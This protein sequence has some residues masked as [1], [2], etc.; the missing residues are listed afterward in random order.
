VGIA[1]V[2]LI[3]GMVAPAGAAAKGQLKVA[4]SLPAP[5]FWNGDTPAALNGGYE[6]GIAKDIAKRLGYSGFSVKNVSFDALVAGKVKG[7]DVALSQV[8]ITPERAKVVGFTVPYFNSDLGILVKKGTTVDKSNL[9]D[10]Q[11]GVQGATTSQTYLKDKVKPTKTPRS[12]TETTQAFAALEAG[13]VDAVLLDT[14]IVLQQASASNGAL[15]VVGQFKSGEHYGGITTKGSKLL[16]SLNK[17][18]KAEKT[19][20]TLSNLADKYLTAEFGKDPQKVPYL[21]P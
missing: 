9:K 4:T 2:G 20:G 6:W 16:T 17:A 10:I 3:V 7:F 5:G 18:I 11:W 21:T 8:T 1:A 15:E 12:Y 19:D 13:Q 14:S